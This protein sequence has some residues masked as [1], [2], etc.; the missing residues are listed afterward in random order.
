MKTPAWRY[1][2]D[3]LAGRKPRPFKASE[4]EA[5]EVR[6]AI[7]LRSEQ[8]DGEPSEEFVA[9]LRDRLAGEQDRP[10][11]KPP[12]GGNR[13]RFVT[14]AAAAAAAAAAGA[15]IDHL[16]V[17]ATAAAPQ[18]QNLVPDNGEWRAVVASADL[19]DG[20]VR[21][22]DLGA[23]TGFLR[24]SGGEVSAVSAICTH[25]GCRLR[26][27]A[28]ERKLNCPC[29]RTSFNVDGTLAEH[30]LPIA[31]PP[32]PDLLVRE[33]SGRVEVFVPPPA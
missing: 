16:L 28:P 6:V 31:P 7:L 14:A 22:F 20:S 13:R 2:E 4:D 18:K 23:V 17:G 1:V 5:A 30:E 8:D 25:L 10:A 15:G 19:P 9:A 33:S 32:L 29:H 11:E 12:S 27:D 3:L 21:P 26:L 24:R